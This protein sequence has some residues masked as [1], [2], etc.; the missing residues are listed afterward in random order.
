VDNSAKIVRQKEIRSFISSKKVVAFKRVFEQISCSEL[1]LRKDIIE[2]GGMS[3]YTHQRSFVT[4]KN[5]PKFDV[6]GIWFFRGAGFTKHGSSL[7]LVIGLINLSKEGMTR[8]EIEKIMKIKIFQQIQTLLNREQLYRVKIGNKYVYLPEEI[9]KNKKKRFRLIGSRQT[10]ERHEGG[11]GV[12][13][14]VSVLK[15]V[16]QEGDIKMQSLKR[17]VKK[18]SLKISFEKLEKII[19]KSNLDEK[20]MP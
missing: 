4:L 17:W 18:Y 10:E 2:I 8:E 16:L 7:D 15:V 3:S 6:N 1:T 14:L 12:N 5:I 19:L 13:D 11:I 9:I 20:K